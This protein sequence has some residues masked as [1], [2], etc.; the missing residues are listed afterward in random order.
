MQAAYDGQIFLD[1]QKWRAYLRERDLHEKTICVLNPVQRLA[2]FYAA[3]IYPGYLS[4]TGYPVVPNSPLAIPIVTE[5]AK[6]RAAIGQI[7]Q[8]S[9]WEE[10]M[11]NWIRMGATLGDAPVEIVDDVEGGKVYPV[12]INPSLIT[13]VE[14]DDRKNVTSYTL[15]KSVPNPDGTTYN[16]SRTITKE[17]IS[18]FKDYSPFGYDG[19]PAVYP[20]PY[21][22]CPLVWVKHR[23]PG[24]GILPGRPA[25]RDWRKVEELNSDYT[26][27]RMFIRKQALTPMLLAAMGDISP[28]V[29][30]V[31]GEELDLE[32]MFILTA[33]ADGKVH[34]LEGNLQL[35]EAFNAIRLQMEEIDEDHPE[36]KAEEKLADM[37][38]VTGPASQDLLGSARRNVKMACQA[39]DRATKSLH[40]MLIAIGGMRA[41]QGLGGWE[42]LSPQQQKFLPF[43]LDSF[44]KGDIEFTIAPR[45]VLHKL[46]MI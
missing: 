8:W 26:R 18:T 10:N 28:P 15:S 13:Q 20:N 32:D 25:I 42:D 22:F 12:V 40:Q 24:Q 38:Q 14:L 27:L 9:N 43:D 37:S 19:N 41:N 1:N 5:D 45:E 39:Y 21:G 44:V 30:E 29:S 4:S 3:S 35:G 36:L 6:I 17:T 16:Y 46:R 23:D 7:W 11:I 33:A 31:D 34:K 2:D